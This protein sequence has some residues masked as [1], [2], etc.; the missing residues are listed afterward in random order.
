MQA[1]QHTGIRSGDRPLLLI[2]DCTGGR[3]ADVAIQCVTHDLCLAL[4]TL[5]KHA[6]RLGLSIGV[7]QRRNL[8]GSRTD[9]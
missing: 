4:S 8:V 5:I 9:V 2:G 3:C 1:L 6:Q 7:E